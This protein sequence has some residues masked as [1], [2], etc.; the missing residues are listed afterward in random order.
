MAELALKRR[1][2]ELLAA[3]GSGAPASDGGL[4]VEMRATS[5]APVIEPE[6]DKL[7]F[8]A[9]YVGTRKRSANQEGD[10]ETLDVIVLNIITMGKSLVGP[11]LIC[12][13][14]DKDGKSMRTPAWKRCGDDNENVL[15]YTDM[16]RIQPATGRGKWPQLHRYL[17]DPWLVTPNQRLSVGIKAKFIGPQ[18]A[19]SLPRPGSVVMLSN[20][21]ATIW[22][23]TKSKKKKQ[24]DEADAAAAAVA[25][26]SPPANV[27]EASGAVLAVGEVAAVGS[28]VQSIKMPGIF[29]K[30]GGFSKVRKYD[31]IPLEHLIPMV[32]PYERNVLPWSLLAHPSECV[33]PFTALPNMLPIG[34]VVPKP[35]FRLS[36]NRWLRGAVEDAGDDTGKIHWIPPETDKDG[37]E[38]K[39]RDDIGRCSNPWAAHVAVQESGQT[40]ALRH[41]DRQV[42]RAEHEPLRHCA[43]ILRLYHM[44]QGEHQPQR[45]EAVRRALPLARIHLLAAR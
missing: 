2:D 32:M 12:T 40:R 23:P 16:K 29:W 7:T 10:E 43:A 20:A 31:D 21:Y 28:A 38:V 11:T 19:G 24:Q 4:V 35:T 37:K 26:A 3:A 13:D 36:V 22:D 15:V 27:G 8:E 34:M 9:L 6:P 1:R 18:G 33:K 14:I 45:R 41:H 25:A 30:A 39:G 44:Q 17:S 42:F 5:T